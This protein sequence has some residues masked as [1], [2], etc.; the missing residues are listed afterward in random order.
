MQLNIVNL[1]VVCTDVTKVN[2]APRTFENTAF[3][4]IWLSGTV[5]LGVSHSKSLNDVSLKFFLPPI[6]K[7]YVGNLPVIPSSLSSC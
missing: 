1:S 5:F 6:F 4:G 2:A 3:T 7:S